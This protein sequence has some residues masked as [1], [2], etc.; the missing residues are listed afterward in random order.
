MLASLFKGATTTLPA[1]TAAQFYS[2]Y[3]WAVKEEDKRDEIVACFKNGSVLNDML[4]KMMKAD[5]EGRSEDAKKIFEDSMV[6]VVVMMVVRVKHILIHIV[7]SRYS[8]IEHVE[9]NLITDCDD[10]NL[11]F[12]GWRGFTLDFFELL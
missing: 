3:L 4:D 6:M 5:K 10:L 1:D 9:L 7:A 12:S 11:D 8:W 2:G